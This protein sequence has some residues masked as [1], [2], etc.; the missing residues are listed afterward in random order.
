MDTATLQQKYAEIK[1]EATR[2]AGGLEDIPRR[3][4]VLHNLYLDSGENH[5]FSQIATHGALWAY[6]YFEVGGWL[7]RVIANR[8]FYNAREKQYRLGLLQ[9]FAEGFRKVNRLVCID[10]YTNYHFTRQFG[11]TAGAET[12]IPPT[13]LD[14]LN[15]VHAARRAQ[16]PLNA[17]EKREVFQA[18]F[19]CEQEVT[20]A[21]GVKAAVAEFEC[22]VL[23]FLCLRPVVRFAYF[24]SWS[25]LWFGD[26]SATAERIA[27]GLRAYDYAERVG[28]ER[29]RRTMRRYRLLPERAL[30]DPRGCFEEI[31]SG[32]AAFPVK[33]TGEPR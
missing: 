33:G 14:A 26:F 18:S 3:A 16:C 23:K 11:E 20:V 2:L 21:P 25:V 24:P 31:R 30:T 17:A 28:W 1:E 6:R 8:Y 5:A 19:H 29:V 13:L 15:R 10:T 32:K 22:R 27:K 4:I 12:V 9:S 7:G